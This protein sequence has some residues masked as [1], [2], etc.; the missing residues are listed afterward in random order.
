M[1][2]DTFAEIPVA[3]MPTEHP[4]SSPIKT[5]LGRSKTTIPAAPDQVPQSGLKRLATTPGG[6]PGPSARRPVPRASNH[7][8]APRAVDEL[9]LELEDAQPGFTSNVYMSSNPSSFGN[10]GASTN[11]HIYSSAPAQS[12]LQP[13]Q[14][15]IFPAGS[16]SIFMVLDIREGRHSN[17]ALIPDLEAR[18][19][20]I[21]RRALAIGDVAWIAVKT[22]VDG[23]GGPQEC[24]LDFIVERKRTDDLV[25]SVKDGRFHE[26]KVRRLSMTEAILELISG[27]RTVSTQGEWHW[28]GV[29]CCR[30]LSDIKTP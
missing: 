9:E 27:F 26:Q 24:V 3:S 19:V 20:N 17:E 15:Y 6:V 25:G 21:E 7:I 8:P 10:G 16:Y 18:G 28:S 4:S 23:L 11:D 22:S 29:L 30:T 1:A 12:Y 2:I 14:P 13:F 5:S